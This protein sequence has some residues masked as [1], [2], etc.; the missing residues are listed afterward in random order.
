MNAYSKKSTT[1][2]RARVAGM[3][4]AWLLLSALLLVGGPAAA[5]TIENTATVRYTLARASGGTPLQV[6]V[7]SNTVETA[8]LP[9]PTKADIQFLRQVSAATSLPSGASAR[10]YLWVAGDVGPELIPVDGAYCKNSAGLF[11]PI[12][13][14]VGVD[15]MPLAFSSVATEI[16][17]SYFPGEPVIVRVRDGDRN[18]DPLVRDYV[19]VT[20]QTAAGAEQETLRMQ[21]TGISTGV[22]A[23]VL[24]SG[25]TPPAPVEDDC[26]LSLSGSS[27]LVVQYEDPQTA[28]LQVKLKIAVTVTIADVPTEIGKAQLQIDQQVS[29]RE[30]TVGDFVQYRVRVANAGVVPATATRVIDTLPPGMR[31]RAGSA[32]IVARTGA[33]N[34]A[35]GMASPAVTAPDSTALAADGQA[36]SIG[37]GTLA[38]GEAV[39]FTLI[40]EVGSGTRAGPAVNDTIAIAAGGRASDHGQTMLTIRQP[41]LVSQFTIIG[42]VLQGECGADASTLKGVPGVRLLLDDGTYVPTDGNGAYHF[43]GVRPGTHVV[44]LDLASVPAGMEV[45]PCIQNTRFAGRAWSQFVEAQGGSLVRSDFYL[46]SKALATGSVGIRLQATSNPDGLRYTLDLDGGAIAATNL[47]AM[48]MLP[49]GAHYV[50]G[51]ATLDGAS[52]ADPALTGNVAIFQLGDPGAN[53]KHTLGFALATDGDCP[54]GGYSGKAVAMFEAGGKPGQRTPP[55]EVMSPCSSPPAPA[56]AD[57]GRIETTVSAAAAGQAA[58]PFA[59][60][61]EKRAAILDTAAAGGGGDIDWLRG[62]APGTDLLFPAA[63]YN[64][65]APITRVVVK[66][67]PTQKVV[68]RVNGEAASALLYDGGKT[69]ADNAVAVSIWR[70]LPLEEGDNRIDVDILDASGSV[71]TTL[72]RNVHYANVP[73]RA[74]LVPEQSILAA[75]GLHNP[76]IAVRMLDR[77]GRPVRE[78]VSGTFSLAPPYQPADTAQAKQQRQF[79]GLAGGKPTWHIEGD[80]GIAYIELQPTSVA[81]NATL[82]FQFQQQGR[83]SVEP[84][85]LQAWLKSTPRDW[86]VVGFAAGSVGFATLKDNMQALDPA[87]DGSGVR[88]DGQA[89]LYAK[90]RVLGKWML[91]LAYD[92]D[93]PTDRLHRQN[94]LSTIDPQQYY[95][96]Y[97]DGT[98]QGYDASSADKIYLKLERDQFYA[99]VGD[100]QTGM[101]RNELS[102]YQR[103]LNGLKVEYRGP[104]VEFNGFAAKTAQNFARDELPGDGTS[105]LYR[106]SHRGMLIN[107]E[108]VRIETRDRYHSEQIHET[109][110]LVRHLD[111]DIDYSNG[112]LFFREPIASRDFDFNPIFIVVEYETQ[113]GGNEYLNGGGR[114]GVRLMNDRLQAGVSY[115]RDEDMAGRSQLAG[116]DAR[117]KLTAHDELRGEAA[118]SRSDAGATGAAGSGNAW[119]MEWEHRGEQLN[120]LTYARRQDSSFGLGQQNRSEGGTFKA[121]V[122]GQYRL[123]EHFSL[124]G[125]AYQLENMGNGAVRN[126]AQLQLDYRQ[127]SW[128]A[129]AG[130][131]Y[132]HDQAIDGKVAQS[133]Q[134]TLGANRYFFDKRLELNAQA[135][136]SLGGKNE[137]VDFPTR[138]QIGGA[139]KLNDSFRLLAAQ[140]FTDGKDRDTSTTRIGFEAVPWKDARLTSTLNQSQISEYGPRTF[141]LFGLNQKFAFGKHWG[142][143]LAVD[144]SQSFNESGNAPLVVDPSQP[145]AP[146]GLRDGGALTENFV[147]VS[148]GA[149]YRGELWTWN[150]RVEGRQAD[151]SDRYGFTTAFL[152]QIRDGVAMAASMQAFSQRQADGSV[153]LLANAQLSW[154]WRP[155]GSNWSMLNRL[156][157][158]LDQVQRGTGSSLIGQNTLAVTGDARS[159]RL[160]NNFVLNRV[161]DAWQASDGKGNVLDLNQRSQLSLYYGSKYVIDSFDSEDYAGYSDI[162]GLEWR[163][164]LSPKLDIGIRSSVLHS[165]SQGTFSY[166]FG[167]TVGFSP[168]TNTWV[169]VGYNI[170]GFHDRDFEAAHYTAQGA[171]LMLRLKFD[172]STLGL[173]RRSGGPQ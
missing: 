111:Y 56:P 83:Q 81:G 164:D 14:M 19:E 31:Y 135:D 16:A 108:R 50:S 167:P 121:G 41:M 59:G 25:P 163:F 130:L 40:A 39:E 100:F 113:G 109:R 67:L 117:F 82:G 133:Q 64:P 10:G 143:D 21:E 44:Q 52:A 165:W 7:Q 15:G 61:Q 120:L 51:S 33:S 63:D 53:W 43:E 166:A 128:G 103:T 35:A 60:Q 144:S 57:S 157:F 156:E 158:R 110:E 66:H 151:D 36:V 70:A 116:V 123:D 134:L 69:S 101:D 68:V 127:D 96:L 149:T 20:I 92:S 86:V 90:G 169:S 155:L 131:Q 37:L 72:S 2:T 126:A 26:A 27:D 12:P 168:F 139:Y 118:T 42:R 76:V 112:T 85:Q 106:L 47:R 161:S 28:A 11:V 80:D 142:L 8:V 114:V 119:L 5:A 141:A 9:A 77:S 170:K 140:E 3:P 17:D 32:R 71:V 138:L 132:A 150:G 95:T 74:E 104:L 93:K 91:T 58:S 49:E 1:S 29:V 160:I 87:D 75:D 146:G 152:R 46:R 153:G 45:A 159:A 98:A 137:S 154:A 136:L 129:R 124:Q 38:V 88:A 102:R 122:Q 148:A 173:D 13:D 162:L 115:I 99:L 24:Q 4:W 55:A 6:E 30:A 89:S 34:A 54:S 48:A 79:A 22:F 78:G 18:I 171:Y 62:Q 107:S 145:I 65:R 97:G 105:G 125:E 147:A 84:Q 94:L 172:Q 73:M 23:G